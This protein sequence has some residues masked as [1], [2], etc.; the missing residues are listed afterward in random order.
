MH[1]TDDSPERKA[2]VRVRFRDEKWRRVP[3]KGSVMRIGRAADNEIAIP[4]LSLSRVHARISVEGESFVLSD[5]GSRNGTYLNEVALRSEVQLRPGDVIRAGDTTI[6]FHREE[7]SGVRLADNRDSLVEGSVAI[8]AVTLLGSS[9]TAELGAHGKVVELL[10]RVS[11]TLLNQVDLAEVGSEVLDSALSA[12][13]AERGAIMLRDEETGDLAAVASRLAKGETDLV[14]SSAIANV[15]IEDRS[16][17]ITTD[18]QLDPRFDGSQSIG[19]QGIRSAMCAPLEHDGEVSGLLY[20]DRHLSDREFSR[21]DLSIVTVLANLTAAKVEN[22]RLIERSMRMR[23]IEEELAVAAEIQRELLPATHPEMEGWD[24]VATSTPSRSVG[25]DMFDYIDLPNGHM[26]LVVAD[27]SGKGVSAALLMASL[28]AN[29]RA[30]SKSIADPALMVE[31]V[32]DAM[33]CSTRPH[34]F[35]TVFYGELDPKSGA[36]QYVNGGH[37]AGILCRKNGAIE[38]LDVGGMIV[39]S[40]EGIAKYNVGESRFESG[41]VL[42]LYSDGVTE[43]EQSD[44]EMFGEERLEQLIAEQRA[45][46]ASEV[47]QSILSAVDRFTGGEP[48]GDDTTVMVIRRL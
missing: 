15:V 9:L 38:Q 48:L 22:L 47:M 4:D 36:L 1:E 17:L 29:L 13:G 19:F 21:L 24:L 27:V 11:R 33:A 8:P 20:V 39:G 31:A 14:V 6:E 23:K 25:G 2:Y 26:G 41:D 18:A 32:N 5:Q 44:G 43:A 40:F 12:V 3:L 37:N 45:G 16:S 46:S 28:Q 34:K 7:D 10:S 30:F 35:A 42:V